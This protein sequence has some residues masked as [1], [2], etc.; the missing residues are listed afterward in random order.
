METFRL[1]RALSRNA[2]GY[3]HSN[4]LSVPVAHRDPVYLPASAISGHFLCFSLQPW[5]NRPQCLLPASFN[6]HHVSAG[7]MTRSHHLLYTCDEWALGSQ[8]N[9]PGKVICLILWAK[10]LLLQ[11]QNEE[12]HPRVSCQTHDGCHLTQLTA[13]YWFTHRSK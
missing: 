2:F 8:R 9:G 12:P 1:M 4:S 13:A 11:S 10:P 7:K 6:N 3:F 5:Q